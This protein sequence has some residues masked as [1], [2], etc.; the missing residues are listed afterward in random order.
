MKNKSAATRIRRPAVGLFCHLLFVPRASFVNVVSFPHTHI[1]ATLIF[2]NLY[3][4]K[5]RSH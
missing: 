4:I 5:A 1:L 2:Y 3:M